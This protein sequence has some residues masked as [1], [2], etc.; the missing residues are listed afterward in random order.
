MATIE[1]S[2]DTD[3]ESPREW[4]NLGVMACWH[5]GY[6]LG[7]QEK[8]N[9]LIQ[10]SLQDLDSD[11]YDELDFDKQGALLGALIK[12]EIAAVFLPLY[13]YDHSG[14]TINTTGSTC[15]WDSSEIGFIFVSKKSVI[16]EYGDLSEASLAKAHKVL[17]GEVTTY[18]QYIS[19]DIYSFE[20]TEN[21]E[22]IDGCGGFYGR[23]VEKN[24]MLE[25]MDK[26]YHDLAKQA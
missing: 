12:S 18:D 23:D 2:Q 7:D 8:R 20:I 15:Q 10:D 4:D 24:G 5:S 17:L 14:I 25:Q 26:Q 11:R 16:A 22:H 9:E 3:T 6:N 1:I 19:N 21:D 13:L